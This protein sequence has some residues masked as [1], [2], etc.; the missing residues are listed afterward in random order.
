MPGCGLDVV[1]AIVTAPMADVTLPEALEK[2]A[3]KV[4]LQGGIPSVI[5]CEE[6]GTRADFVRYVEEVILPL[7]SRRGFILGMSDNVPPNA[8]F[9]RVEQVARLIA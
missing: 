9:W 6:G 4:T 1:E 5:V 3:G 8:D 2:L 7:R